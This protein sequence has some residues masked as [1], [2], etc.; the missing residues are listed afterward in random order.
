MGTRF[1]CTI[2]APIHVKI[3]ESI[4]AAQE[5]DT[6][7]VLRKWKNTSRLFKN[8]VSSEAY[9]IENDPETK[10]FKAVGPLVSGARGRQVFVNGDPDFGVCFFLF[11]SFFYPTS[12]FI[13]S[14]SKTNKKKQVWTAGQVVGLIHDIPSCETLVSRIESEAIASLQ[15]ASALIVHDDKIHAKL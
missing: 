13:L 2:E 11:F 5:T 3:K 1:M 15:Q 7:L 14:K 8:K 6:Q 10:E 9:R 4:V 12:S